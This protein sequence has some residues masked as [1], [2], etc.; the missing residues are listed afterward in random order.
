[1]A[2]I[3]EMTVDS[4]TTILELFLRLDLS[5]LKISMR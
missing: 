1:M 4:N 3:G 2:V 5:M